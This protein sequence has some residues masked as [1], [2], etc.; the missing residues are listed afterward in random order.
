MEMKLL[1]PY[2]VC[3]VYDTGSFLLRLI[4]Q[5]DAEDLLGCYSDPESIPLFN[6]DNCLYGFS[7]HLLDDMKATIEAWLAEYRA[8]GFVRFSIID[9]TTGR[10]IGTVEFF[11][12]AVLSADGQ[13]EAGILRL[14]LISGYEREA[15]LC[16]ILELVESRFGEYFA[17]N[18]ILTKAVPQAAARISVLLR[19]GYQRIEPSSDLPY[20]DYYIKEINSGS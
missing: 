13:Q 18:S 5:E 11:T 12:R 15:V 2:T 19:L 17:F 10:V 4:Q 3:P 8:R 9:Q 16:E 6:S 1:D 14:D 20:D 7:M